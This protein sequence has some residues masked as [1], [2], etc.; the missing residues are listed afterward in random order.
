MNEHDVKLGGNYVLRGHSCIVEERRGFYDE[1]GKCTGEDTFLV[2]LGDG[3]VEP[4]DAKDLE[5]AK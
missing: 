4:C 5:P 2:K 3:S 1:H